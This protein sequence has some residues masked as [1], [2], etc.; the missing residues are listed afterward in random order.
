MP[1]VLRQTVG[2]NDEPLS[3]TEVKL[4]LRLTSDLEDALLLLYMQAAR[5]EVERVTRRQL[6]TA[7]W[8]LSLDSFTCNIIKLP[9]A[10]LQS[11]TSITYLDTDGDSQTLATTVYGVDT[12]SE[13]GRVYLKTG[14]SWPSTYDQLNAITITYVAGWA[15]YAQVPSPLKRLILL[16]VGHMYEHREAS[17]EKA[18]AL[19]P[20][21]VER[22]AWLYRVEVLD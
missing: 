20:E 18:L 14:Q 4:H 12:L 2:P 13:P 10:P 22:L 7:T 15:T 8:T 5:E 6:M 3:L 19:I 21:G 1:L 9:R 17:V 11:V 16:L